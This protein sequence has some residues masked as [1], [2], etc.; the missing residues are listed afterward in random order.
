ME[1][2]KEKE[3]EEGEEGGGRGVDWKEGKTIKVKELNEGTAR[4]CQDLSFVPACL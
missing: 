2:E 3:G 4:T 1:A